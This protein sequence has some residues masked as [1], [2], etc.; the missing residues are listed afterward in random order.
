MTREQ[1]IRGTRRDS[2][3]SIAEKC[4]SNLKAQSLSSLNQAMQF[5][6]AIAANATQRHLNPS[7]LYGTKGPGTLKLHSQTNEPVFAAPNTERP[8]AHV[9]ELRLAKHHKTVLQKKRA[10]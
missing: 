7:E 9:I 5:A 8:N 3:M 4:V 2:N 6:P 1:S 10:Q